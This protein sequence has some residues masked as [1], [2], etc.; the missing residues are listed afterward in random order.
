MIYI[1]FVS[2]VRICASIGSAVTADACVALVVFVARAATRQCY[3][4]SAGFAG[5]AGAGCPTG[6]ASV[7]TL[8]TNVVADVDGVLGCA[9]VLSFFAWTC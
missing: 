8:V 7:G 3:G 2:R 9:V 4:A 5:G 6:G 1:T